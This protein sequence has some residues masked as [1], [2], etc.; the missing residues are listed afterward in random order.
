MQARSVGPR[1]CRPAYRRHRIRMGLQRPR[2][3]QPDLQAEVRRLAARMARA[4][5]AVTHLR[6]RLACCHPRHLACGDVA[7]PAARTP[8]PRTP[9][10]WSLKPWTPK[11]W[12]PKPWTPKP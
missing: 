1:P 9:R 3:L 4:P 8:K 5:V 2:P 11:P 6:I 7:E 10:P 12:T